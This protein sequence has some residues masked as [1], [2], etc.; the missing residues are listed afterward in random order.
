MQH[1][2]V[3]S[4][5]FA[6]SDVTIVGEDARHIRQVM[7][8]KPSDRIVCANNRG[9]AFLCELLSFMGEAVRARILS[10]LDHQPELPVHV[11]IVQ[12]IPK[13]DKFDLIVQKGTECGARAFIPFQAE[14]SV[15]VW[16]P[17]R[18]EKKR[19]RLEKIA[20]D[21][22]RQS[23]RLFIPEIMRPMTLDDLLLLAGSYAF[24]AVAYE[25]TA[26][27]GDHSALPALFRTMKPGDRLLA[28]IG[29]EGGLSPKEAERLAS[30]GFRLCGMGPRVMRTETAALYLLSALSF[31]FE[32]SRSLR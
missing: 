26:K 8:M 24:K 30:A 20:K 1:Y 5:Q 11:T 2:F 29:P 27:K 6:E 25:E 18:Q 28:V 10:G 12:G 23:G 4:D 3:P 16:N 22:A 32:L 7:R 9:D 21:A 15:S 19:R 13:G 14:R 31:H 17:E